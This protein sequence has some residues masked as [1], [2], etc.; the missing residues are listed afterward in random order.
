M[1][2]SPGLSNSSCKECEEIANELREAYREAY[3]RNP[4]A[5]DAIRSLIGGTEEDAER[6]EK[7]LSTYR[8][9]PYPASPQFPPRLQRALLKSDQHF[10]RTGH[11]QKV[12]WK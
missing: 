9:K 6:A 7:L 4:D 8:F 1:R 3:Q 11:L 10:M 2:Q 5:C 12:A